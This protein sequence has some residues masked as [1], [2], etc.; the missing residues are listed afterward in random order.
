MTLSEMKER[1]KELGY[2]NEQIAD[3]SNVPLSTVQKIFSGATQAPR[4]ET[5]RAIEEILTDR[6]AMAVRDAAIQYGRPIEK[7]QG[8]YTVADYYA[9]P[10]DERIELIDGVIYDMSAPQLMHQDLVGE[11]SYALKTYIRKNKGKC[12]VYEAPVDVQL[13]CDD[14]T[15][16]Q[17]DVIVVCDKDKFTKKNV[18]GAPD[19]V[20]E[21]LSKWTKKKDMSI[22]LSK[23]IN[24]GVREYWMI[25]PE[26]EVVIV[27]DIE[28]DLQVGVYNFESQ[29]PV[30]IFGGDCVIDF[31]EIK[32][33]L[34]E[35]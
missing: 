12:R 31:K 21:V 6:P 17:P 22:K 3:W 32:G 2:T 4:Y 24:A 27:Y 35:F 19:L 30:Q 23:Y 33:Y 5:L 25:D 16:V 13:D 15:M 9:W 28:N 20:V 18:F 34:E 11:M 7:R 26:K 29:I 14:K 10:Q 1:K 8:E